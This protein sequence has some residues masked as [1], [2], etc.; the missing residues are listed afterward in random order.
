MSASKAKFD[1][2]NSE[3]ITVNRKKPSKGKHDNPNATFVVDNK[4][5]PFDVFIQDNKPVKGK[6]IIPVPLQPTET[7]E[8]VNGKANG[9]LVDKKKKVKST[10]QKEHS[11]KKKFTTNPSF[12]PDVKR[13][14]GGDIQALLVESKTHFPDSKSIWLKDVTAYLNSLIQYEVVD[15]VFSGKPANYPACLLK[16]EVVQ[17]VTGLFDECS[18]QTLQLFQEYCLET[19]IKNLNSLKLPILGYLVILQIL[20]EYQPNI[21]LI[22]IKH[23]SDGKVS[24]KGSQETTLTLLWIIKQAIINDPGNGLKLWF[25]VFYPVAIKKPYIDFSVY[26]LEQFLKTR[27]NKKSKKELNLPSKVFFTIFDFI[28]G[29]QGLPIAQSKRYKDCLPS[30]KTIVITKNNEKL[31]EFFLQFLIRSEGKGTT[32]QQKEESVSGCRECISLSPN[33]LPAV[34]EKRPE[35]LIRVAA[36]LEILSVDGFLQTIPK[37][38]LVKTMTLLRTASRQQMSKANA[39]QLENNLDRLKVS[40]INFFYSRQ[41]FFMSQKYTQDI[42][43]VSNQVVRKQC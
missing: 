10:K 33:L 16:K 37:D 35:Q 23:F 27:E 34:C 32:K 31:D 25:D 28:L 4:P 21:T 26:C 5:S 42:F 6:H 11:V 3:W 41:S 24:T 17:E 1:P 30:L 13:I 43:A 8:N 36:L 9:N 18:T 38:I 40:F 14:S 7:K 29:H 22:N 15:P 2:N 12:E 20:A 19:V 39:S